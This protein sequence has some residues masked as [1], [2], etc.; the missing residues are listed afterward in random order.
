MQE[1][2]PFSLRSKLLDRL[3]AL[4]EQP[5]DLVLKDPGLL[6]EMLRL[7]SEVFLGS[8]PCSTCERNH[9]GYY[10]KLVNEGEAKINKN[11]IMA[12]QKSCELKP[13]ALLF[14]K[15]AHYTNANITDS[16]AKQI[17][18]Q[19][20]AL[21]NQFLVYPE[22]YEI[23]DPNVKLTEAKKGLGEAK[24]KIGASIRKKN[25][26]LEILKEKEAA[27]NEISE[28]LEKNREEIVKVTEALEAKEK[29]AVEMKKVIETHEAALKGG[30]EAAGKKKEK[31]EAS[32]KVMTEEIEKGLDH[33][34]K[35]NESIKEPGEAEAEYK[36]AQGVVSDLEVEIEEAESNVAKYETLLAKRDK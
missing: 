33:V 34:E 26:A 24:R 17:L 12:K 30:D 28:D 8:R 32:L 15:G 5:V 36:Q 7:Y 21:E 2:K 6:M 13:K 35:L 23:Q 18:K 31:A 20:P 19:F 4:K 14:H 29:D 25:K 3:S 9:R 27:F 11:N 16:T 22:G 10:R 1:V